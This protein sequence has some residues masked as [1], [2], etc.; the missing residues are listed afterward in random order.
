MLL[1]VVLFLVLLGFAPNAEAD[2]SGAEDQGSDIFVIVHRPMIARD[3]IFKTPILQKLIKN[4]GAVHLIGDVMGVKSFEEALPFCEEAIQN[5]SKDLFPYIRASILCDEQKRL[6][7]L[8]PEARVFLKEF[9][10]KPDS[11]QSLMYALL[12]LP[13]PLELSMGLYENPSLISCYLEKLSEV[14]EAMCPLFKNIFSGADLALMQLF[15]SETTFLTELR[16]ALFKVRSDL[17]A[18]QH[19]YFFFHYLWQRNAWS[20]CC[21]RMSE[22]KGLSELSLED[23][24]KEQAFLMRIS[25]FSTLAQRPRQ[26]EVFL[27]YVRNQDP[28]SG[29]WRALQCH[30]SFSSLDDALSY[31]WAYAYHKWAGNPGVKDMIPPEGC[32]PQ[33]LSN[34]SVRACEVGRPRVLEQVLDATDR[35]EAPPR[36]KGRKLC[37]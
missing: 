24:Q 31:A 37:G 19:E 11:D 17:T 4:Q 33:L 1:M 30:L 12:G 28:S 2:F 13:S 16:S 35:E 26:A 25:A 20:K 7:S 36:K 15:L 27:K 8:M 29:C 34:L 32:Y 22:Q 9:T 6:D 10:Q 23:D 14:T 21:P 18:R 5:F 3:R